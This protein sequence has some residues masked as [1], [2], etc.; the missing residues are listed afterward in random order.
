M[1]ELESF[2]V[3]CLRRSALALAAA[4]SATA[5]AARAAL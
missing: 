1:L 4:A 5:E 2:V 3:P